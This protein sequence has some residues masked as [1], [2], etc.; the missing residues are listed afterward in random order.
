MTASSHLGRSGA[1]LLGLYIAL[2]LPITAAVGQSDILPRN[3]RQAATA[4]ADNVEEIIGMLPTTREHFEIRIN[5]CE[6]A[7]GEMRDNIYAV[8]IG[9]RLV[10]E[11][12]DADRIIL[13]VLDDWRERGWTITRDRVLDNG[14]V[15][16]AAV[17]PASGNSYS[18]DSGFAP[19]PGRYLVGHFSSPC[20]EEPVGAAP[21]G[22]VKAK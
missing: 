19:H 1:G 17:D 5:R 3:S 6:G 18:F 12:N 14:G 2:C 13:T 7:R 11:M 16:I 22:R 20:F 10:A 8:W 4:F 15:N 9:T 21:F